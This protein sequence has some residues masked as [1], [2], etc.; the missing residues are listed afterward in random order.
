MIVYLL[1]IVDTDFFKVGIS[2]NVEQRLYDI[3][4]GMPLPVALV[5]SFD[6]ENAREVERTI[7]QIL[8]KH[9]V[10]G[11]WFQIDNDTAIQAFMAGNTMGMVDAALDEP[12][13][14]DEDAG[15]SEPSR[16][17]VAVA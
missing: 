1:R 4:A 6:Q 2:T 16:A 14:Y 15:F 13:V 5:N 3:Q 7:H 9:R 8:D 11:E 12:D 10:R 17:I